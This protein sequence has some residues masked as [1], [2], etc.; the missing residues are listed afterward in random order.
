MNGARRRS[1][2][3]GRWLYRQRALF[4]VRPARGGSGREKGHPEKMGGCP[5]FSP[6]PGHDSHQNGLDVDI[7]NQ[8]TGALSDD[9]IAIFTADADCIAVFTSNGSIT[10]GGEVSW[11]DGHDTHFHVRYEDPDGLEN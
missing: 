2:S 9:L 3:R 10:L 11:V 6:F 7:A 5:H 1:G 8:A 4:D